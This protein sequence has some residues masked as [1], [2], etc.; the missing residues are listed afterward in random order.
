MRNN[1]YRPFHVTRIISTKPEVPQKVS[2]EKRIPPPP[3]VNAQGI[4]QSPAL[5]KLADEIMKLSM[6]DLYQLTKLIQV[7]FAYYFYSL[8]LVNVVTSWNFRRYVT[9]CRWSW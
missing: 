4:V 7:H 8:Y 5:E 6:L 3:A 2:E 1:T 9:P